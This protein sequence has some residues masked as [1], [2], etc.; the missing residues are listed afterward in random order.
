MTDLNTKA[1]GGLLALL[2]VMAAL[3][4]VPAWSLKYWQ[5][6][7]FL[8][9]LGVGGHPVPDEER[10]KAPGAARVRRA[11]CREGVDSKNHSDHRVIWVRRDTGCFRA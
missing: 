2:A 11:N 9:V 6:W 5:A 10:P 7:M 1:F 3:L 4:F 8:A